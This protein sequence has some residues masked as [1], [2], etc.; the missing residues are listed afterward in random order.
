MTEL[1]CP[2]LPAP[3]SLRGGAVEIVAEGADWL[4]VSKPPHLLV[5]PTRPGGPI[6]LLDL[7]RDLLLYELACGGQVSL[8]HRLDR[9]TSGVMLIAKTAEAAR[10]FSMELMRGGFRKEYLA[11][12]WGWPEWDALTVDAP[13]LRQ[14]TRMPSAIWLK[15]TIHPDGAPARTRLETVH[16]FERPT[17]DGTGRF[18]LVR[19]HPETGRMHQIRVH[20]ASTGHPVVGDK[21]YGP[22]EGCYLRF[23]ETGWTPK[24]A[25]TL[26]L[27]RHALHAH[28]LTFERESG[29]HCTVEAPLPADMADFSI[30]NPD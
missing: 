4:A 21:I 12:V 18:A 30:D 26:L 14:G 27:D 1:P 9:E 6:T 3:L 2:P 7:L 13:L 16:R 15:Q 19:V 11:L 5:H 23:I 25:R 8:I 24:L 22:D 10:R 28:R 17:P 29:I 20:L